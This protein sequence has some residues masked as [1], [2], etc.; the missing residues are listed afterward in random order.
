[1]PRLVVGLGG[2]T[3]SSMSERVGLSPVKVRTTLAPD[4]VS[5]ATS[6]AAGREPTAGTKCGDH[7]IVHLVPEA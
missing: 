3:V 6:G 7:S 2:A 4:Y 1:M 5:V